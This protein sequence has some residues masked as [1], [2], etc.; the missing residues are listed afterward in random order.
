M[1]IRGLDRARTSARRHTKWSLGYLGHYLSTA[2]SIGY[3]HRGLFDSRPRLASPRLQLFLCLLEP[4]RHTISSAIPVTRLHGANSIPVCLLFPLPIRR[5]RRRSQA[6]RVNQGS[7]VASQGYLLLVLLDSFYFFIS[8]PSNL[9]LSS[10]LSHVLG[11]IV[12]WPNR[13]WIGGWSGATTPIDTRRARKKNRTVYLLLL[14]RMSEW[15]KDWNVLFLYFL[16]SAFVLQR[17]T[18]DVS[19]S[20]VPNFSTDSFEQKFLELTFLQVF[21]KRT[22][23]ERVYF[24]FLNWIKSQLLKKSMFK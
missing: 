15:R 6:P 20:S 1:K 19:R 24:I 13:R 9:P 7:H 5:R 23:N 14:K 4:R 10:S 21:G 12:D 16:L 22:L 8:W 3:E 18:E 17:V 2:K 11:N